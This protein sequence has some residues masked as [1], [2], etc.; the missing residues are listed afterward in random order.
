MGNPHAVI[1]V[2]DV[3]NYPVAAVGPSVEH[4]PAFPRRINTEFIEVLSDQ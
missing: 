3:K 2:D 1:F 4:H